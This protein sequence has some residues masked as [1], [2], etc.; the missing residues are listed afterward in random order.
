MILVPYIEKIKCCYVA[1]TKVCNTNSVGS[2]LVSATL[3]IDKH[4]QR[5]HELRR[6]RSHNKVLPFAILLRDKY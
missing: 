6:N 4:Q 2:D 5:L 3:R 1:S